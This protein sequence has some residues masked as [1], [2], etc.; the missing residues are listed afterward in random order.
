[1]WIFAT[2]YGGSPSLFPHT[3]HRKYH[4]NCGEG[5]QR[6]TSQLSIGE[7]LLSHQEHVFITSKT[8]RHLEGLPGVCLFAR[9]AGAHTA[10]TG[11]FEDGAVK[12]EEVKL[13]RSMHKKYPYLPKSWKEDEQSDWESFDNMV[14]AYICHFSPKPDNLYIEK[15]VDLGVKPGQMLGMLKAGKDI[16][17]DDE[18]VV[19]SS[20][21]GWNIFSS[22]L[23]VL[24]VPDLDNPQFF[25]LVQERKQ[26]A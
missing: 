15:V 10:D 23:L 19:K 9:A 1:M 18:R 12:V 24:D 26:H 8:W 22:T 25:H 5:T 17:L 6:L 3:D 13:D 11:V 4:L 7:A 21:V 16:T 2:S 20:S 14:Q